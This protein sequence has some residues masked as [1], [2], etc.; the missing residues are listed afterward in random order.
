M[1]ATATLP[2]VAGRD[3]RLGAHA[4][5][6]VELL[7]RLPRSVLQARHEDVV[8]AA[9]GLDVRHRAGAVASEV[10]VAQRRHG[11]VDRLA[12]DEPA[13]VGAGRSRARGPRRA[14]RRERTSRRRRIGSVELLWGQANDAA[15]RAV[16]QLQPAAGAKVTRRAGAARLSAAGAGRRAASRGAGASRPRGGPS[17]C[18]GPPSARR[19]RRPSR[20][21]AGRPPPARAST[22]R[23]GEAHGARRGRRRWSRAR[24]AEADER[25][26]QPGVGRHDLGVAAQRRRRTP[27]TGSSISSAARMFS[28]VMRNF[29]ATSASIRRVLRREVAVDGADAD[30]GDRARRR[31]SGRSRR[32]RRTP[33]GRPRG[34]ARGCGAH[35]PA[36]AVRRCG[37]RWPWLGKY[38]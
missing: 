16:R 26:A 37:D 21:H 5:V 8:H 23:A 11:P 36:G 34:C 20:R 7:R 1:K 38:G 29:S 25:V 6:A 32:A 27:P 35:R 10:E 31:R 2:A 4:E 30:P 13:H 18:T 3:D 19:R 22:S 15:T 17:S 28:V 14:G 33:R 9:H 12:G 24:R